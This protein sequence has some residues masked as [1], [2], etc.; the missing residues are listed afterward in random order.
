MGYPQQ[1]ALTAYLRYLEPPVNRYWTDHVAETIAA[2]PQ[3]HI[4][5]LVEAGVL[6]K[7]P[8]AFIDPLI[9]GPAYVVVQPHKHEWQVRVWTGSRRPT[10]LDVECDCGESRLVPNRLPIEVPE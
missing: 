1:A 8:D 6:E 10:T 3:A 2:D 5:A 7:Q 4:D 9:K